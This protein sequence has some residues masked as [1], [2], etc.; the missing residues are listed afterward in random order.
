MTITTSRVDMNSTLTAYGLPTLAAIDAEVAARR[1]RGC[2]PRKSR[3]NE[4]NRYGC[5]CGACSAAAA[6]YRQAQRS[7]TRQRARAAGARA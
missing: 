4:Y 7:L 2:T 6:L 3:V 5:H 1:I